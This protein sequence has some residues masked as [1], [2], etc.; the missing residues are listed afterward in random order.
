MHS[1]IK[2]TVSHAPF[3]HN[4]SRISAKSYNIMLAS[5]LAVVPGFYFYGLPAVA[6]AALAVGSAMAWELV[7]NLISRRPVSIGDGNAALIGLLAAMLLPA[8][9]PWWIVVIATFIAVIIG[10]QIFGGIGANPFNPVAVAMAILLV[11]WPDYLDF[12]TALVHYQFDFEPVTYPLLMVKSFGADAVETMNWMDLLMGRQVGGIGTTFGI[13]LLIA[14]VYLMVRGYIRWEISLSFLA[15]IIITAFIFNKIDPES[16]AGPVFHIVTG[17][18]LIG[19]FMLAT[20]DS[21]SPVNFI[22]MLLYG[23]LGGA[24]TILIRNVGLHVDGVIFA[25][26]VMNMVNPL[27]D[28]IR[29]KAVGKVA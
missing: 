21:S 6:A 9:V 19:A 10:K 26:L 29:P 20:E 5:M 28:K 8:T 15:G 25:V 27:I 3:C 13:G 18:T 7:F 17:Y 11:S 16:Y 1:A 14:G 4:G 23:A 2:L 24:F 22:P 12:N